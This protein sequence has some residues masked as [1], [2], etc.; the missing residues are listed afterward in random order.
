MDNYIIELLVNR[1]L[2]EF[3]NIITNYIVFVYGKA[4]FGSI[5]TLS[6]EKVIDL[7]DLT[8]REKQLVSLILQGCS[9]LQISEKLFISTYTVKEHIK[10]IFRKMNLK[11]RS[12]LIIKVYADRGWISLP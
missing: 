12:E 6:A 4:W 5:L 1:E 2:D 7:Y 9:N 3:G 10:S 8:D 11:S